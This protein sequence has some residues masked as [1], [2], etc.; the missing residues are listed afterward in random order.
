MKA[1]FSYLALLVFCFDFYFVSAYVSQSPSFRIEYD[2][3]NSEG[4]IGSSATYSLED[5]MGE[6]SIG[7]SESAN[8]KIKAGF[9]QMREINLSI[10]SPSDVVLPSIGGLTG[11]SS[12]GSAS[13]VV[14]TD[15]AGG[16]SLNARTTTTPSMTSSGSSVADYT[17]QDSQKPD[18]LWSVAST[19][20]EFGFSVKG[21]DIIS[22]FKDNGFDQCATGNNQSSNRCWYNFNVT[23]QTISQSTSRNDPTGTATNFDFKAE[24]GANRFQEPGDYVAE[25]VVTAF[26]N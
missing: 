5:T 10:S 25:I 26:A 1:F 23:N 19:A 24:V 12:T 22:K 7:I 6:Q 15:N 8:F 9:Q 20:S 13:W 18:F 16:Y 14:A 21:A 17:P 3:L 11:G 4:G 2:S